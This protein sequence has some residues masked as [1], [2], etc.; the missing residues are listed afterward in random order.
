MNLFQLILKQMRQ[1]ALSTCL[2]LIS[3]VLGVALAVAILLF[4]RESA[5]LFGQNEFGYDVLIGSKGNKLQLVLNTVYHISEGQPPI[6]YSYY[7]DFPLMSAVDWIVPFAVGDHYKSYRIVG[8]LPKI[9]L[10]FPDAHRRLGELAQEQTKLVLAKNAGSEDVSS[11]V[12]AQRKMRDELKA[13]QK[14]LADNAPDAAGKIGKAISQIDW[15]VNVIADD[16]GRTNPRDLQQQ[17]TG[18]LWAA[19]AMAGGP[20]EYRP[21]RSFTLASGRVF[22]SRKFEA[23]VGSEAASRLGLRIGSTF[24]AEH[25]TGSELHPDE[26]DE[27]WTVVGILKPTHT[28]NDRVIFIPLTSFYAI[29][30]HE[31]GLEAISQIAGGAA[32]EPETRPTTRHA[33]HDEH[34][35][36][37]HE[38]AYDMLP[39]G[40]I[41]LKLPE[42]D[43]RVSSV[44]ARAKGAW[45]LQIIWDV[46]NGKVAMAVNPAQE[47]QTFFNTFLRGGTY[48]LLVVSLL[49]TIVAAVSIL[50]SI[51]NSVSAR[52]KEIA[53]MRALGATRAKVLTLICMEAGIIGLAGR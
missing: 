41:K 49:V 3:V 7:R 47:M 37:H 35:E 5:K 45:T 27:Q 40:T 9:L 15:I 8:T 19:Q 32:E 20:F 25:G 31:K 4:Q 50:V 33:E 46:N 53:V 21:G 43:W 22:H 36:H 34:G 30:A 1:R 16:K 11:R 18:T 23:V 44:A 24:K 52:R 39:D 6:P 48:L 14:E 17:T 28:A 51:Y 13:I 42:D 29:P 26:H 10:S 12:A 2:T 38:E